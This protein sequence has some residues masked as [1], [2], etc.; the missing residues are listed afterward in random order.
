MKPKISAKIDVESRDNIDRVAAEG[1]SYISAAG[2]I[3][4]FFLTWLQ[5][6]SCIWRKRVSARLSL[7]AFGR[8]G[9]SYM[10]SPLSD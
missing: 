1:L 9:E 4:G 7:P 3:L 6:R 2:L 10:L 5:L 8:I